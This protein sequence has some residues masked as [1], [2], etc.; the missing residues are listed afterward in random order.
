MYQ[1]QKAI[2]W[3]D[4][5]CKRDIATVGGKGANLGE[6]I[7]ANI[8]VPPGFIVTA[9]AYSDFLQNSNIVNKILELLRP[10]DPGNFN[11]LQ[12]VAAKVQQVVL[13]VPMPMELAREIQS[14]Y[15]KMG[16]GPVAVRSSA[17]AEDL[18]EASFAGQQSTFLNVVGE[19]EVVAAVQECWASLFEARAISY[20]Q[21]QGLDHLKVNIAVPVQKMVQSE[22][23][24]VMFTV[25]P[26][27]N[28]TGQIVIEAIYGL[29]ELIVSGEVT[30]DTYIIDKEGLVICDKTISSQGFM[31]V[32]NPGQGDTTKKVPV[33]IFQKAVQKLYD[34]DIIRLAKLGKQI[35]ELYQFPQDIEWAKEGEEIYILQARPVTT[36]K[37]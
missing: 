4:E 17:T 27:T 10:L 31:L 3:F 26:L 32:K 24:G 7:N 35:E 15:L 16:G 5:V 6:L 23:A 1:H 33:S 8:P 12:E 22:A 18:P 25:H 14:A 11:Q 29:G 21:Q 20:R 2:V 9:G 30:P 13:N 36:I 19:R 34:R 37:P 28:D